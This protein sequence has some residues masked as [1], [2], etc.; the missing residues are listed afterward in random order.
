LLVL[1]LALR[2]AEIRRVVNSNGDPCAG[3]SE[4][5]VVRRL[6]REDVQGAEFLPHHVLP[7]PLITAIDIAGRQ[8]IY[9]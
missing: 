4:P 9:Y 8:A 7:P 3:L 2:L 1:L 6:F 5:F